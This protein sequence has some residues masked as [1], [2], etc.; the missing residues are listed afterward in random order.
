M[1]PS[2]EGS[3]PRV[4]A[5]AFAN[6]VVCHGFQPLGGAVQRE[7]AVGAGAAVSVVLTPPGPS[8]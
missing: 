4:P 7:V 5:D 8:R 6:T 2:F 1:R 3:G